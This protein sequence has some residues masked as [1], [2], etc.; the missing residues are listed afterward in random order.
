MNRVSGT[1]KD[2]IG[3]P[4]GF[5]NSFDETSIVANFSADT[6]DNVQFPHKGM[7]FDAAYANSTSWLNG[8]GR[9]D[10]V[11]FGG[12]HPF[13][14]GKNT[15]GFNYQFGNAMN[16]GPDEV[17]LFQL[18]GFLNLSAYFPGQLTGNYRGSAGLI[19]Y[20][21]VAGGLRLL[22]QTPIYIGAL[23]EAGNVWNNKSDVSLDDLHNSAGL[24]VGADTFLGPVYLGYAVGDDDQSAAFLYIG[25]IF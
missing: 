11:Q 5:K 24:F 19:Y 7:V 15:M 18:G 2:R 22:T 16:G 1:V 9:V 3:F 23:L 14:W 12:Y 6:L 4:D 10:T 13:T 25:Q 17:G 20:R 21:R 8:D